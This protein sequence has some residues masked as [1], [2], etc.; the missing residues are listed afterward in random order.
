MFITKPPQRIENSLGIVVTVSTRFD[1]TRMRQREAYW[2]AQIV[3]DLVKQYQDAGY[4]GSCSTSLSG[5]SGVSGL[6]INIPGVSFVVP[7]VAKIPIIG[8]FFSSFFGGKPKKPSVPCADIYV[9]A[10]PQ[11]HQIAMD[12]ENARI[13]QEQTQ[14][15]QQHQ[16]V[17]TQQSVTASSFQLPEGITSISK[18]ALVIAPTGGPVEKR[19]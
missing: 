19:K 4:E 1:P 13:V 12:E 14:V 15:E 10:R 3:S 7:I 17:I 6:G 8:G 16:T 18:G 9:M 11:A 5:L 2:F